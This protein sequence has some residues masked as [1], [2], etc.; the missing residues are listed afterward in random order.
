MIDG[1][2]SIT[3]DMKKTKNIC[4]LIYARQVFRKINLIFQEP[5][6]D[7]NFRVVSKRK[8]SDIL[9]AQNYKIKDRVVLPINKRLR[10]DR[11]VLNFQVHPNLH[12]DLSSY[13]FDDVYYETY[14]LRFESHRFEIYYEFIIAHTALYLP[15]EYG[16][17][18]N[19]E[20][21]TKNNFLNH[22]IFSKKHQFKRRSVQGVFVFNFGFEKVRL[23]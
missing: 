22:K 18:Q 19:S 20:F 23:R 15:R 14:L 17:I 11:I 4:D 8:E 6:L 12:T 13:L 16:K 21:C 7:R 9:E 2:S 1:T 5:S 10:F 3:V